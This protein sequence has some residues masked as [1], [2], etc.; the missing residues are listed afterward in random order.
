VLDDLGSYQA[1]LRDASPQGV[2]WQILAVL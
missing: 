2:G 1:T